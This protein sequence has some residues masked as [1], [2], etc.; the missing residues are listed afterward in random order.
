MGILLLVSLHS[1]GLAQTTE[2]LIANLQSP[3]AKTR[4]E[5]ARKLGERR[6]REAAEPLARVLRTDAR[7]DVRRE[8]AR[9]L[10]LIKDEATIPALLAALADAN[11]DV[12]RAAILALVSFYIETN[13]EFITAERRGWQILNPFL[14]TYE[15]TLVE[16]ETSVDERII[17]GLLRV[18]QSDGD[19]GVRYAAIRALGVLRATT[20][21]PQLGRLF[22]GHS[23]LRVEILKTFMKLGDPSAGP[24]IIPFLNDSDAAVRKSALIAVGLLR[25]T[26]A[27]P[28]LI[29]VFER[30]RDEETARLALEALALIGD[31]AAEKIFLQNLEHPLPERRR[32]AAEGLGRLG[33]TAYVERISRLRLQERDRSAQ[34]AQAFA[35]YRLGRREFLEA[36]FQELD[37]GHHAQAAAYLL[38][39]EPQDL[40]PFLQRGSPRARR[41]VTEA[42]G[43]T[44]SR[45]AIEHLRPLLRAEDPDLVNAANLAIQRIERRERA[46]SVSPEP[47]T[48]PRRVGKPNA[49]S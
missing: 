8:A 20:I 3:L 5:A 27:V 17:Q 12:R 13:I 39:V 35:L 2:E 23:A 22:V 16:P 38:E 36:I 31:R 25:V 19:L 34:L 11:R 37:G 32:F 44:G 33:D 18:A 40:Y 42:L 43:R 7:A 46:K 24:Y 47:R 48:R 15:A 26:E 6:Q 49:S 21:V 14:S 10:G 29:E 1:G 45:E 41:A 4:L 9:A 30:P 28:K